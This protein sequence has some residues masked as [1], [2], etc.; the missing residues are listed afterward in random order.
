M[1]RLLVLY[2]E[3][4]DPAHFRDYYVNKHV[5]LAKTLPG[6]KAD[7]YTFEA[8]PLGLQAALFCV[9]EGDFDSEAS[10]M[11]ALQSKEGK[12]VAGDVSNYATGGVTMVHYDVA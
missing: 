11:A 10:M 9:F 4:K 6:L 3:P 8:K 7:R 5:P 1:H 12:A 2:N